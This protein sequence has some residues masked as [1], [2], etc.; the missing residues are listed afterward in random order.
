MFGP[1]PY[2]KSYPDL[3][4]VPRQV[5][6]DFFPKKAKGQIK[7]DCS[8]KYNILGRKVKYFLHDC[9]PL[10]SGGTLFGAFQA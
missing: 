1:R 9:W 7:V 6:E 8:L 5:Q 3:P 4:I 10:F 2:G